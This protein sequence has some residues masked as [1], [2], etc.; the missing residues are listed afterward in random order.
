MRMTASHAGRLQGR[1]PMEIVTGETPDISEYLDFGFYDW[2]WFKRDAGIGEIE[3]G[4]FLGIS[5]STGSLMSYFVLPS[6][7]VPVSRTTVQRMTEIEKQTD[8]N[9]QR[10]A[11]FEKAIADRYKEGRL[12]THGDKPDLEQW[13]DLLETDPHFAEEFAQTFDNPDVKEADDEFDPDSYDSYLNMEIAV[14]RDGQE[15]QLA[16]VS[17]R[18]RDNAGNPIGQANN[19]PILDTRLY[20]IE[21][22]DGH[23]AAMSANTIAENMFAQVDQDGHRLILFDEIIGH[24]V[25]GS[26]V[27]EG[28][29]DIITNSLGVKRQVQTTK[30]WEINIQWRDGSTTWN[31]LK[32]IKDSYPVQMA[33]YATDNGLAL[34][35]VFR[36][37]IPHVLKKRDRIIAKTKLS[38]WAKTHKYGFEVPKDYN[39]CVRIDRENGDTLWQDGVRKEMKTVRPAFEEYEGD[40]KDLIGYQK[41]DVQFVFDIKLGEDFRRKARLVALGNRTTTP[42]TLTYSSVVSRDSVRIALT[43]AALNDLDILVCDIEGAYLTAKCREKVFIE[44][45]AAFGSEA[46][47]IMI[48]KMALYGLK[49]SGAAFRSKLAGVL[50]DLGYRPTYAD[51]DVW[52][53]A[54]VKPCGFE[55]YEMVL[56][57]VDDVMVISHK[58]QGTIEGIQSVF[59]LKGDKAGPPD[60]YLGVTLEKK[61]NAQGTDCWTMS[62]EKYV[63]AAVENVEKKIGTLPYSK[64][65][66]PTPMKTGYHPAEDDTPELNAE[67][68]RYYQELIG[69]LRWAVEIGRLD[70]LLEVALLSSHLAMPR[71]GHLEQAYHIFAYLKH[72][73]KRRVYL[74]PTYPSISEDRFATYDWTDFYRYAEE[75]IPSNMPTPRGRYMSLHCFVDSDHAGDKVT[76]RSQTGILIFCNSAPI[77][78]YSKRQNSVE[79]STYGSELVAMRQAIELVKSLRYKLRMFGI[80]IEGA[81]DIFCDNES[82][83]KNTSRPESVLNKKQHSISYHSAREAVAAKIVRIAKE[84]T[85]TNLS[86]LFTKTM[87]KPRREVLLDSF[88]Y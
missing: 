30:G 15:A 87:N 24:R 81:T 9:R 80:P 6:S 25:D 45:G 57:Y 33:E 58:P 21:Y 2:V 18:L 26:Q 67:G 16:R 78:A 70:I 11:D 28:N 49:S 53:K 14:D 74:D 84:D 47:K 8:A 41:I 54:A 82:V 40:I 10:M 86:D 56:C 75:A 37:W 71:K 31:T 79:C 77:L 36:W 43:I 12:H 63:K 55:Y 68:L 60:M 22:L 20:E 42:S 52:L 69:I 50:H 4:K 62:P 23:R 1:T 61:K 13:S 29:D 5:S 72:S 17:K 19:N 59:K 64:G 7:G 39:D 3:I 44:A 32:D 65:Q 66:C 73:G 88:M 34:K 85:R 76:R 83:Y 27:Q 46:G 48:V 35:P 38:Y 51:P